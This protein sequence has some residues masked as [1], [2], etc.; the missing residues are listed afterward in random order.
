MSTKLEKLLTFISDNE[1]H[2]T[3][4]VA[5]ALQIS[6]EKAQK[7][8]KFLAEADLVTYNSET[9]QIKLKQNWKT[10]I[11]N[12]KETA[13]TEQVQLETT[14]V[15]TIIVPPQK[16]IIIQNTH[17]ANLTDVPLELEIRVDKKITEIA[18]NKI[19]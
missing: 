9:R 10:L 2:T 16:T 6:Q 4:E 5:N 11:I 12:Q 18:I 13:P 7:I 17:I 8:T 14:A 1:W 15:G 3:E 19:A